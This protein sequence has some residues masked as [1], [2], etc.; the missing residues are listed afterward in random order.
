MEKGWHRTL[1]VMLGGLAGIFTLELIA[2]MSGFTILI[3]CSVV[4]L[5]FF[6]WLGLQN[7][8]LA[9]PFAQAGLV[10]SL[11]IMPLDG[12]LGDFGNA[13]ERLWGI[14]FGWAIASLFWTLPVIPRWLIALRESRETGVA[15]T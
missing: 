6:C 4:F 12:R 8:S 3:V 10:Y 9:Y 15:V 2:N 11:V 13:T 14:A 5:S 1:G 7:E